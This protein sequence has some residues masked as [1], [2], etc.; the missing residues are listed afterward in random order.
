LIAKA[1]IWLLENQG[2]EQSSVGKT[3]L[4]LCSL[5]YDCL[6]FLRWFQKWWYCCFTIKKQ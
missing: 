2:I 3:F 1:I 4:F 6:S 5:P